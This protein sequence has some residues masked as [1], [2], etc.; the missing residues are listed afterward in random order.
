MTE[1]IVR[2]AGIASGV[3]K[4]EDYALRAVSTS[5]DELGTLIGAFNQMLER[6]QERDA[7]QR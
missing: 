2:L 6:I 3:T 4:G 1:P 7:A 5:N